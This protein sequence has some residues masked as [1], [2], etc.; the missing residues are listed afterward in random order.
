[1]YSALYNF[2][3][4][5]FITTQS[6]KKNNPTIINT[7]THVYVWTARYKLLC[8]ARTDLFCLSWCSCTCTLTIIFMYIDKSDK[9]CFSCTTMFP[10]D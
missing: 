10:E 5:Q 4:N 8:N 6:S 1:M 2:F 9:S 3:Y 7:F